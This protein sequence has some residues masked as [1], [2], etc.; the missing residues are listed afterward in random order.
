MLLIL[1]RPVLAADDGNNYAVWG[2]G[3]RSCIS[4]MESREDNNSSRYKDYVAGYLT[5]T[6]LLMDKTY[7][8]SDKLSLPEIFEWLD[9]YCDT[10]STSSFERALVDFGVKHYEKRRRT[11]SGSQW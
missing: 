6:N 3:Q 4:Y 5:A 10:Q 8:I 7:S 2:L 9:E 11:A 1:S